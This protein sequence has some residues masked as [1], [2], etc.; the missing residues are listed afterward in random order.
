MNLY[1][2]YNHEL[3]EFRSK[4]YLH[5]FKKKYPKLDAHHLLNHRIDYLLYP[6]KH[7]YHLQIVHQHRAYYFEKMLKESVEI[8]LRYVN[9]RFFEK[10]DQELKLSDI[11]PA[12]LKAL[13]EKIQ[14]L[15]KEKK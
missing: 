13:F 2:K 1:T 9:E 3:Y 8:L 4:D 10:F 6:V 5:W 12:T 7:S 14:E 11:E 15:E